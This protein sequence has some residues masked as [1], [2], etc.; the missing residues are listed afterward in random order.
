MSP[1][2]IEAPVDPTAEKYWG[3]VD[4]YIGGGEH[5]CLHLLYARF[6]HQVRHSPL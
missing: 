3:P 1:G 5:A 2:C 4:L 6:W